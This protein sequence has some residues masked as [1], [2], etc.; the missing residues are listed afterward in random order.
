MKQL[1]VSLVMVLFLSACDSAP[2]T[3]DTQDESKEV[4]PEL[5]TNPATAS[6]PTKKPEAY[7]VMTF[8]NMSHNFGDILE[9]QK[10]ETVYEFTNTGKVDLLIS[11]CSAMCGCTVPSWPREPIKPGEKGSIKVVFDSAGKGGV[12]NKIV[13]VYANVESKTI[14][15]KFTANVRPIK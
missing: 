7:A 8:K 4:S 13:T 5:I 2:K 14:E 9:N 15:L 12:N 10:V 1:F 3:E 11:E 6:D